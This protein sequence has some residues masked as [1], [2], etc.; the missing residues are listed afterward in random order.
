MNSKALTSPDGSTRTVRRMINP[1][2][3][4]T[5]RPFCSIGVLFDNTSKL[6]HA[7]GAKQVQCDVCVQPWVFSCA[8]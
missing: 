3:D 6:A 1:K 2:H 5:R 7:I 8:E 4:A